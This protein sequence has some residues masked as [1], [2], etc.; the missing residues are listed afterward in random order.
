MDWTS[1]QALL[2]VPRK[3]YVKKL[4]EYAALLRPCQQAV[5][6]LANTP[7][8]EQFPHDLELTA[9]ETHK[10]LNTLIAL[11]RQAE[12]LDFEPERLQ[13][14]LKGHVEEQLSELLVDI[15]SRMKEGTF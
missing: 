9:E 13:A 2:K 14:L 5:P 6:P 15:L 4:L 12:S 3:K 8:G 11:V 7:I 10:L 1:L